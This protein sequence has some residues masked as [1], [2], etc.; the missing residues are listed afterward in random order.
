MTLPTEEQIRAA[1]T[2]VMDPEIHIDI[3]NLG[4][5][6]KIDRNE[7]THHVQV[8]MG[9]TSPACPYIPELKRDAENA[10]QTLPNVKSVLV[11]ITFSPPWDPRTMA[12]DEAKDILGIF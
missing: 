2:E 8:S 4:L 10:V 5:I 12:S 11:E 9:V 7:E 1:L 6:Y 3:V